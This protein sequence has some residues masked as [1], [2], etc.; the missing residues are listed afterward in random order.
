MKRGK[1]GRALRVEASNRAMAQ[2]ITARDGLRSGRFSQEQVYAAVLSGLHMA[3]LV[4][5][6]AVGVCSDLPVG[7]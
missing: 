2:L 4:L 7:R 6:D 3:E 1:Q 5:N